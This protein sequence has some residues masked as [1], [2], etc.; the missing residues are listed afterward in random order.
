M[1]TF[2]HPINTLLLGFKYALIVTLGLMLLSPK[3]QYNM[4]V[5]L[6]ITL[7]ALNS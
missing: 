7:A 2:T 6:T 5:S 1:K 3:L 4:R